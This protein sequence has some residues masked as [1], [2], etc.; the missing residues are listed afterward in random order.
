MSKI[1]PVKG[2]EEYKKLF[3]KEQK[4]D[5][6][7]NDKKELRDNIKDALAIAVDTRKL[8]IE[9]Y[10]KRATY[11]WAFIAATFVAYFTL[12][13]KGGVSSGFIIPISIIGYFFSLGWYFVN[14]GSKLWQKNWEEHV[15]YLESIIHRPLFATVRVPKGQFY[16]LSK[17]YPFSVSKVNQNLSFMMVIFW[18]CTT[19]YS[20]FIIIDIPLASK[21]IDVYF[22]QFVIRCLFVGL[23]FVILVLLSYVFYKK[24]LCF[25]KDNDE[26]KSVL[27]R[28]KEADFVR[29]KLEE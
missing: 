24:S 9:L 28:H 15:L 5:G 27:N 6:A 10:W 16:N 23:V 13:N 22:L 11:F 17:A 4:S 1:E 25:L 20:S 2:I 26:Y 18:F 8:E 19:I 29:K 12:W 14:R 21:F 7:E 3:Y